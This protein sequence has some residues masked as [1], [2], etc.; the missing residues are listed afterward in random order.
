MLGISEVFE[1]HYMP[2]DVT[3]HHGFCAHGSINNTT[4]RDLLGYLWSFSP[5]DTRYW[6]ENGSS[7]NPGSLRLRAEDESEFPV[8]YRPAPFANGV[9]AKL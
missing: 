6:G 7:G 9:E 2:G 3:V 8:M 4:D 1:T 5:A